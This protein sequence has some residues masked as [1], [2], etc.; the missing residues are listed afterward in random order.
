[1]LDY[2]RINITWTWHGTTTFATALGGFPPEI[3]TMGMPL[4]QQNLRFMRLAY[5]DTAKSEPK[6]HVLKRHSCSFCSIFGPFWSPY[7]LILVAKVLLGTDET[8]WNHILQYFTLTLLYYGWLGS[9]LILTDSGPKGILEPC[10][11]DLCRSRQPG[12]SPEDFGDLA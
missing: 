10:C 11:K 9:G 5:S 12:A 1:M 6:T 2:Q 7:D 8:S 3:R 4:W